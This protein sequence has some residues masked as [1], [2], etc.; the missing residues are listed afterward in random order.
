MKKPTKLLNLVGFSTVCISTGGE[1]GI[2]LVQKSLIKSILRKACYLSDSS[3]DSLYNEMSS[4]AKFNVLKDSKLHGNK[5]ANL[6]KIWTGF[7]SVRVV[8]KGKIFPIR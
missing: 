7:G 4:C 1:R 5:K 3:T 2:C 6:I 8:R